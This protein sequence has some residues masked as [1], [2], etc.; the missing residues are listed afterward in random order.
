MKIE[1]YPLPPLEMPE[2]VEGL[3]AENA[4]RLEFWFEDSACRRADR[5]E[6]FMINSLE[7]VTSK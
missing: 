1:N 6:R 2:L 4:R 5:A 7:K 3:P